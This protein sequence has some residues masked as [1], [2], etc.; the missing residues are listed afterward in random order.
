M[1]TTTLGLGEKCCREVVVVVVVVV[2]VGVVGDVGGL[3]L[4]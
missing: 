4:Q 2:V 1:L 3:C